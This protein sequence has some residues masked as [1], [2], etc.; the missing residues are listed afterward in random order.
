[1]REREGKDLLLSECCFNKYVLGWLG[2][3]VPVAQ[4]QPL[5]ALKAF[6][7]F[8]CLLTD[9]MFAKQSTQTLKRYFILRQF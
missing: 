6:N 8:N 5:K 7:G 1:M 2:K 3:G 9:N 4:L